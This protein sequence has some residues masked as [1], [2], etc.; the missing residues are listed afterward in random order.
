[1]RL[2]R[3]KFTVRQMMVIVCLAALLLV[4]TPSLSF[5]MEWYVWYGVS[6]WASGAGNVPRGNFIVNQRL[7]TFLI[8]ALS[9]VAV[10][11][12]PNRR[13][14]WAAIVADMSAVF[15]WILM[16]RLMGMAGPVGTLIWPE[17]FFA[18]F[19]GKYPDLRSMYAPFYRFFVPNLGESIDLLSLAV[20][21]CLL[22][23]MLRRPLPHRVRAIGVVAVLVYPCG[24]WVVRMWSDRH[25]GLGKAPLRGNLGRYPMPRP[26]AID[27]MSG[28]LIAG[29][30]IFAI[31]IWLRSRPPTTVEKL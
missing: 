15:S 23:S 14:V 27:L 13:L 18:A 5:I 31:M 24:E 1:M 16:P 28:C 30:I 29:L 6:P 25:L 11:R 8:P 4:L 20:L 12:K 9:W 7:G 10:L 17:S 19:Q 21:L 3:V 22:G 26:S 2:P